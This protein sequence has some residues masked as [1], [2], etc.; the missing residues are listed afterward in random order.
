[1]R[2]HITTRGDVL[3]WQRD[4]RKRRVDPHRASTEKGGIVN[5][6]AKEI[7]PIT[8]DVVRPRVLFA[9]SKQQVRILDLLTTRFMI[10]GRDDLPWV[11]LKLEPSRAARERVLTESERAS[12]SRTI[13]RLRRHGFITVT[14]RPAQIGITELGSRMVSFC[15]KQ[16]FWSG[17]AR[18]LKAFD[19][20]ER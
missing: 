16:P 10:M 19:A 14:S 15:R 12:L 18:G 8:G 1:M 6:W 17:Y 20:D 5:I 7:N 4:M 13:R 9:L 3:Q 11:L 2:Y